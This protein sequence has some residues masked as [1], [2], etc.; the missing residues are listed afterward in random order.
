MRLPK[1]LL[2]QNYIKPRLFLCEVDKTKICEL[3][4]IEM[5]GVFKFNAYSELTFTV[6]R[7]YTNMITGETSVNPFYNK[8][9]A[10]RLVYLENFGYFEIQDP[11][12]VSDGIREVKN[13]TAYGLEYVLSQK[14]I[15]GFNVNTGENNSIE[16][17][18]ATGGKITPVTLYNLSNKNLS[19]LHIILE[20]VYG[21]SIGHV[22]ASLQTMS[23]MFEISRVSVYDFIVQ[24]IC[25]K[26][27]CF[28]VFDTINN[29]INLYAETLISK[30]VGDGVTTSFSVLPVYDSIGSVT[31]DGYKT[32]E[33]TYN[34]STGVLM[35]KTPP[36]NGAKI[37]VADGSQTQWN[38]DVYVTFENL[39]Q[40]VS[41]G[42]NADDIKTVLTVKGADD[43]DIRE[44]NMGLP[45][46]VDL[47]YYYTVDWMGQE[48]YDAYT[49]YLQTCDDGQSEYKSNSEKM[50]EING[51]ISYE[52]NRLSLQYSIADNV[53][54]TTV[55]TY[56]VRGGTAPDYYYT[57]VKLPD[58]YN[59][60]IENYYML[61]GS[62][63]DETKF[64]NF[65]EALKTYFI[66]ENEKDTSKLIDL[67]K[68]FAFMEINTIDAL[69]NSLTN[70][71]S[72]NLKNIAIKNFLNELW[73]Q[74][75]VT[76]LKSLYYE[77]YKKIKETN[78]DA[79]W[80]NSNNDNYWNYYPVTL[81]IESL[82]QE[83]AER[84]ETIDQYKEEYNAISQRNS[85]IAEEAL[86]YNNFTPK[87]LIRL[88]AFLREDEYTD[89][90][91]IE[92]SSD[93]IETLM[94]TKQELLE[95]GRIELSKLCEPKLEFSMDMAN[96]YALTEF[97][98]II[99]QFQLGNLINVELRKDY[100]KRA[101]LLEVNIN[102]DDFSDFSCSFGELTNL[103]TPSSIHA[104]LLA[105]ALTAGK[106]VASN[107]SY[108]NKGADIATSTDLKIQQ[109]LL[110]AI[111]GL[112]TSDQSLTIDDNGI[113]L[114]KVN[115]DGSF[116]PYQ[117]W[118]KNNTILL[119]STG[120]AEG[121]V[122]ELGLGEFTVDGD[123][124][125]GILA[126]V[127][128][129]G[130]IESSTMVGGTIRIGKRPDGTYAFEV[131]EHGNVSML[132]GDVKFTEDANSISET[133]NNLND[134]INGTNATIALTQ[135]AIE[136]EVKRAENA[137]SSIK[138]SIKIN[139]DA[140][141]SKVE[142][143]DF[144]TLIEQNYDHVKIAWNN[145]SKYIA[146]ENGAINVYTS[147]SHSSD[148]LLMKQNY[149]GAWY[150]NDGYTIGKIGTNKWSDD[151]S[152]RGL[153][154][155]LKNSADYMCWAYEEEPGASGY[156]VKLIYHAN[157]S[158]E[159]AGL[160]FKCN[161][162]ANGYLYL[163][164]DDKFKSWSNGGCGYDG[165]MTWCNKSNVS[166]VEID[167]P[168]K[169]FN[170]YSGCNFYVNTVCDFNL[171]S[172]SSFS[173]TSKDTSDAST[174]MIGN[175][176]KIDIW[177]DVNMHN[178][179]LID[180]SI[181]QSSDVRLKTNIQDT[182]VDALG[183]IN[184]IEMKQFDWIESG[185]HEDIGMIAQQLETIC[186]DLIYTDE[187]TGKLSIKI[188]KFIPYL[189]KSIQELTQYITGE[190][191]TFSFNRKLI[192]N[193]TIEEKNQFVLNNSNYK[194]YSCDEINKHVEAEVIT[195][196]LLLP[197]EQKGDNNN[198]Q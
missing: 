135:N 16:V 173:L 122:S 119:S 46:L 152:Y 32:T 93:T 151:S 57:E 14:Y 188:N 106:S 164:D 2:S 105:T 115:E 26:F 69:V 81:I 22:D 84:Q 80:N 58:D 134:R 62:D 78:E 67:K 120:F 41:I 104:D 171:H 108:W 43:L 70:A 66:S 63:I 165:R 94:K 116:S 174:F 177:N 56:Y 82:E 159:P 85:E 156:T 179:N 136:A 72:L 33:Y 103:K 88:S 29:K 6:P 89:D 167:G 28:A 23:R 183:I 87:Q 150:Y 155:D 187:S 92:T 170:V 149:Q 184:Q 97:E 44:V 178:W 109:G 185:Q 15:E 40:E 193:Y 25:E 39:A 13:V 9:E 162:Y 68:E 195:P 175:H 10:L 19:L 21:W 133:Y 86:I 55:G 59:A 132:G 76:P 34:A 142:R 123:T 113:L 126:K 141:A 129:S 73:N 5:S 98:P 18:Y 127:I 54:S 77:P 181:T 111:G 124:F 147:S 138:S 37:E 114:R 128:L 180:T 52:Q 64:S 36:E 160:H 148:T 60:S 42:Y 198:E 139:A 189:I 99:H 117:A 166:Y 146:F 157:D 169:L 24:D 17:I 45:Y 4:T 131:D 153:V 35:L 110:G 182:D 90:N 192:D 176:V 65:Y 186:P 61:S 71:S 79:G 38:T 48:L 27:N 144:G 125:Y 20:K 197:I 11:E 100:I 75:G 49:K 196:A 191:S 96:I 53:T 158:K 50:L 30:H 47:S 130:Y 95:C 168:N 194:T 112:Y 172:G 74:L 101:R 51:Q 121:S 145:N 83:I 107:A 1:D 137:E 140:I 102:F 7:T 3:E 143:N 190:A 91:F 118:L 163:T 12:I 8:I 161:T 31:I 154:F